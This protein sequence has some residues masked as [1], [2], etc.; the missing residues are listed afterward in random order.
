MVA[1]RQQADHA[2]DRGSR[3]GPLANRSLGVA[4]EEEVA[5]GPAA[6]EGQQTP[7]RVVLFLVQLAV[8]P[9]AK[10]TLWID[11]CLPDVAY[12]SPQ[13]TPR[14]AAKRA[15]FGVGSALSEAIRS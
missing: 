9:L 5:D 10:L 7:A 11:W 8:P 4:A 13:K 14:Q 3:I 15:P 12:R 2:A 1:A 6:K